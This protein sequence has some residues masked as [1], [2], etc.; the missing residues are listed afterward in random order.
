MPNLR[1]KTLINWIVWFILVIIWNYGY[2]LASPLEDVLV[3]L[4]LS[5]VLIFL[6][7]INY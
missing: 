2:P 3:A 4:I 1:K 6:N 5:V 7:R